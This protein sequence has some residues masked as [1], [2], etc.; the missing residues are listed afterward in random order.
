[1]VA[2]TSPNGAAAEDA[3]A[4]AWVRLKRR[5]AA[6]AA[7]WPDPARRFHSEAEIARQSGLSRVTVRRAL[8]ALE[9]EGLLR[10]VQGAGSFVRAAPLAEDI[11][12]TME[13]DKGWRAAGHIAVARILACRPVRA[14]AGAAAALGLKR[15][16]RLLFVKRLRAVDGVPVAIDERLVPATV[17]AACGLDAASAA[18]SIIALLWRAGPLREGSWSVSAR[19]PNAEEMRLLGIGPAQPVLLRHMSYVAADDRTVLTGHSVHRADM[20]RY[21]LSLPLRPQGLAEDTLRAE[22]APA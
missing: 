6:D 21:T 4:P 5:L 11:T 7:G 13:V 15:G 19:P 14:S 16:A 22:I 1:M 10:R 20:M 17:A 18:G 8:A 3:F 9:A 12:P 2:D